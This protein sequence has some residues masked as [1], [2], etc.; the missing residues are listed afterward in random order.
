MRNLFFVLSLCCPLFASASFEEAEKVLLNWFEQN[1]E[2]EGTKC[3]KVQTQEAGYVSQHR[4]DDL[5]WADNC[6]GGLS[7]WIGGNSNPV[8]GAVATV[9]AGVA[10]VGVWPAAVLLAAGVAY[11][12]EKIAQKTDVRKQGEEFVTFSSQREHDRYVAARLLLLIGGFHASHASLGT[13]DSYMIS[14]LYNEWASSVGLPVSE[15]DKQ[16]V[17]LATLALRINKE[18]HKYKPADV[19][20]AC[21]RH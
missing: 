21:A 4:F 9:V 8:P 1:P 3:I 11:G 15:A 12:A 16:P 18:M 20:C 17:D 14:K 7:C 2:E 6:V 5:R 10:T 13:E 19:Q